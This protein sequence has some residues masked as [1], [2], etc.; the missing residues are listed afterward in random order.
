MGAFCEICQEEFAGNCN[1]HRFSL[2]KKSNFQEKRQTL[3][4]RTRLDV[5]G[6][7]VFMKE[8]LPIDNDA[9]IARKVQQLSEGLG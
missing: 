3:D 9:T 5:L 2:K 1:L 4:A 6:S 8:H 7:L